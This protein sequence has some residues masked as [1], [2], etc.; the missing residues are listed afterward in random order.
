MPS[1]GHLGCELR[2]QTFRV[3]LQRQDWTEGCKWILW[4]SS[5][6]RGQQAESLGRTQLPAGS[7]FSAMA[8]SPGVITISW[9]H[10]SSFPTHLPL[11]CLD[12]SAILLFSPLGSKRE[13][14]F[15]TSPGE[16]AH[17][18][19]MYMDLSRLAK[20]YYYHTRTGAGKLR[21]I[22]QIWSTA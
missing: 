4:P 17:Y 3:W 21:T 22:S 7:S 18:D 14:C 15:L 1:G 13:S 20:A 12:A 9:L 10:I 2:V 19:H 6:G 11:L 16:P 8:S 5:S